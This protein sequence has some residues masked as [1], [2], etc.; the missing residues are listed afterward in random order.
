MV[1]MGDCGD[2]L[3]RCMFVY[4]WQLFKI[5]LGFTPRRK[6]WKAG[7]SQNGDFLPRFGIYPFLAAFQGTSIPKRFG[8]T[9]FRPFRE[10][11]V[12]LFDPVSPPPVFLM[13]HIRMKIAIPR[14]FSSRSITSG[15]DEA[16]LAGLTRRETTA[17]APLRCAG[18]HSMKHYP[19][20]TAKWQKQGA[21]IAIR[22]AT[23]EKPKIHPK[24]IRNSP[25]SVKFA[26]AKI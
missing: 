7:S 6:P 15:S 20:F 23:E 18:T 12:A 17:R 8:T 10:V 11:C 3:L 9:L 24:H 5:V 25:Q 13:C 19:L 1:A 14:I 21:K 26:E 16:R 22:A 4:S 2:A